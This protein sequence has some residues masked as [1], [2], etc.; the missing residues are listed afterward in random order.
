MGDPSSPKCVCQGCERDA[1]NSGSNPSWSRRPV[2]PAGELLSRWDSDGPQDPGSRC[3]TER[4]KFTVP[5]YLLWGDAQDAGGPSRNSLV[6]TKEGQTG[7]GTRVARGPPNL[8][9]PSRPLLPLK[10]WLSSANRWSEPPSLKPGDTSHGVCPKQKSAPG[11]RCPLAGD[12][13]EGDPMK[14]KWG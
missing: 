11:S 5:A 6:A 7:P 14:S 2:S 10:Q 4:D 13:N 3:I 1:R 9:G 8:A 12:G